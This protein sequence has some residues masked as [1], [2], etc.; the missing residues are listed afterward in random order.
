MTHTTSEKLAGVALGVA[1]A[2]AAFYVLKTPA[3]RRIAWRFAVI[4]VTRTLPMWFRREVANAWEESGR[5]R[6]AADPLLSDR[7]A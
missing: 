5:S 4:G 3:L 6:S 7:P 1:V 2:G